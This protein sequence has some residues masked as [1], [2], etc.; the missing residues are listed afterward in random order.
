MKKAMIL[1]LLLFG[2][3]TQANSANDPVDENKQKQYEYL[4]KAKYFE[5]RAKLAAGEITLEEAQKIWQK[6]LR[7][8]RKKEGK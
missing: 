4:K 5:I 7:K 6:N 8:I 2:M 1:G 3:M